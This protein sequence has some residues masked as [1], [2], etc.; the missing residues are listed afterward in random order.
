MAHNIRKKTYVFNVY[1]ITPIEI[2]PIIY[3]LGYFR[4][5]FY[6]FLCLKISVCKRIGCMKFYFGYTNSH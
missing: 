3:K 4:D 2:E 1:K 6:D 5:R